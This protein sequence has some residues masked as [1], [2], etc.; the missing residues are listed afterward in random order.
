MVDKSKLCKQYLARI[1]QRV[2]VVDNDNKYEFYATVQETWH[3]NKSRFEDTQ[4]KIGTVK[5][6]YY[7]Y[8]G[9]SD[10]DI[11]SMSDDAVLECDGSKYIFVKKERIK[12]ADTIQ[13]YS[14]MLKKV[15]EGDINDD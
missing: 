13:F 12:S 15:Y 1:G 3:R 7:L 10:V 6:N 11:C 9:P 4:T 8:I 14:G 2:C 5:K